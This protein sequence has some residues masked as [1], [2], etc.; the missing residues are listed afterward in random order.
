MQ[1]NLEQRKLVQSKPVGHS[2]IRG[3][4]GSGKTTVAVNRIPFL[5]ENYCLDK[6]DRV[7]MVTY[8]KSLVSYIKYIYEKAKKDK[9]YELISL[10]EIDDNKLDIK[11]IDALMY[12]Y[13]LEYCKAENLKLQ[14]ENKRAVLNNI[15][16]KSMV[17]V[18][19]SF[20]DI[21]IL[22]L[23]N[24][25]F[26]LEEIAWIKACRYMDIEEYQNTDRLG[27]M[28]NQ[29]GDGPQKLQKNSKTRS[30]IFRV[31]EVYNSD[32]RAENKIDFQ[33]MSL[34][35][36]EQARKKPLKKYTHIISDESQDLTRVQLEFV[37]ALIN[38]KNYSSVLFVADIAQSI[39]PQSWLVKGRSFS[40][41]GFDVKGRSNI[42]A[43]NYRTTTQ[44]AEAAYSLLEKDT[45]ITEDE[46]FVKPSL[47]DKQGVYP[48]FRAFENKQKEAQYVINLI[49]ELSKN[50]NHGDIAVIGRT[51]DQINEFAG[52]LAAAGVAHKI[53]NHK[54]GYEFGDEKVK[55]LTM[56]AIKGLE[57]K[58]VIMIGLNSKSMPLKSINA[59][60]EDY[61]E[62][63]ERKLMYV[64]MTRATERLYMTADGFP[65]KFIGDINPRF[66][67]YDEKIKMGNFYSLPT[68]KYAFKNKLKDSYSQEEKVRQWI[69]NELKE[70]YK[71]PE[72]LIDI[73]YQVNSFSRV[74]YVDVVVSIYNNNN[75]KKVPYIFV[76]VKRPGAGISNCLEQLKSYISTS[77]TCQYGIATDGVDLVIINK[78]LEAVKD[79]PDFKP[80]MLP[81]SLENYCYVDL[82]NNG[83]Y[84]FTRDCGNIKELVFDSDEVPEFEDLR[85][86]NVFNG[87]AAGNPIMIDSNMEE[88]FYLPDNWFAGNS[89][90][91]MV[92][93]KGDSMINAGINEGDLVVIK[94]QSTANNYEIAAVDL[95]GNATLKRFVRMGDSILLMP[96]NPSY[97][98]VSVMEGEVR[99]LGVVVGVVKRF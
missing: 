56:H 68:G 31:M 96:E 53:M 89:D 42:L 41:V 69:I 61:F 10:F 26:I 29:T 76:E 22:D 87:I 97:E 93:V 2:L 49:G 18:R 58:A 84:K 48:I 98:P 79:I 91:Y 34:L 60:E 7:L 70:S 3:V 59:D 15:V 77:S 50:Y 24:L 38:N 72:R 25:N 78:D 45:F 28:A 9:D 83:Q 74:G 23:R 19:K 32:M 55:V 5:L 65:S 20:D 63:R 33:G 73:E 40:S 47:M 27:R 4:A 92:K 88:E 85:R 35:A 44:I 17:E 30:A 52:C 1:L 62:S 46:N 21:K 37:A 12:K 80:G 71:Y 66:L 86:I 43:K 39:Y 8:N 99:I 81:S 94:Q 82:R 54:D 67:K 64:G 95:D 11:N 6:D 16:L 90:C 36:L 13:Y 51:N 57:F 75:N 14:L